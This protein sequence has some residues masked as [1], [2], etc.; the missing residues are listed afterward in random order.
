MG[1]NWFAFT[2]QGGI[3]TTSSHRRK[4]GNQFLYQFGVGKR[5]C[6]NKEWLF[7]WIVELTGTYTWKDNI[8]GKVDK[9]SGGN[10]VYLTPSLWLS[11]VKSLVLQFGAGFPILQQLNGHQE[12]NKYLLQL[13]AGWTF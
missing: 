5:I 2:S 1:V 7:D 3:I 6:N 13:N 12:R 11:S 9:N 8:H 4:F 10:I